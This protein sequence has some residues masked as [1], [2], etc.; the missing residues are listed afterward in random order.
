[1]TEWLTFSLFS[2]FTPSKRQPHSLL[3]SP[4]CRNKQEWVGI[5]YTN[6]SGMPPGQMLLWNLPRT[7]CSAWWD[8]LL[9]GDTK[10]TGRCFHT[11][12]SQFPSLARSSPRNGMAGIAFFL[13]V[14]SGLCST[15][16]HSL[17]LASSHNFLLS[18]S[19]LLPCN[20]SL[21][22]LVWSSGHICISINIATEICI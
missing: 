16:L 17:F 4:V 1:M 18:T 10:D 13:I 21:S 14:L 9:V 7:L 15:A 2:L 12:L 19:G 22:T 8:A 5:C 11:L 3:L 20:R 6:S